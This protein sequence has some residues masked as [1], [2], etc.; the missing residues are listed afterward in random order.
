MREIL[1]AAIK[2]NK[3]KILS[4]AIEVVVALGLFFYFQIKSHQETKQAEKLSSSIVHWKE[5]ELQSTKTADSLKVI[6]LEAKI[7]SLEGDKSKLDKSLHETQKRNAILKRISFQ[8]DI[9]RQAYADSLHKA[10]F[11]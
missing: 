10:L 2:K 6:S 8:T 3:Y 7:S 5:Y 1:I 9:Q 4:Y 11:K